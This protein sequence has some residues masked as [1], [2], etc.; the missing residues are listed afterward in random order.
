[1]NLSLVMPFHVSRK[2]SLMMVEK[3]CSVLD[4]VLAKT[5]NFLNE[6][7]HLT[8]IFFV[9]RDDIHPMAMKHLNF[10]IP[11][12]KE[13][14]VT[15]IVQKRKGVGGA[16]RDAFENVTSDYVL[17]MD[18]DGEANP[19]TIP[20]MIQEIKDNDIVVASRWCKC[21]LSIGYDRTKK[22]LAI[23]YNSIFKKL[24][25]SS[26]DDHTFVMKLART[27][28]LKSLPYHGE[29]QDVNAE[30]IMY[31]IARGY[32]VCQVPTIWKRRFGTSET[33]LSLTENLRFV[34][35]GLKAVAIK[36]GILK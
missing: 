30:S 8:D 5:F 32:K 12:I 2:N 10:I 21:G 20:A 22:I 31:A 26:I 9:I 23:I 11:H 4:H 15:V 3:D 17:T 14:K 19:D 7:V 33:S 24:L 1:M 16:Y 28:C 29:Y 36:Y 35:V 34:P 18:S 6:S 27:E 25:K 13:V